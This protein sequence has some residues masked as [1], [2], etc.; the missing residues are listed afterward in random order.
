MT[1]AAAG[2]I[3]LAFALDAAAGEPPE[4]LHPVVHLGTAIDA[5]DR[6]WTRPVLVGGLVAFAVPLVS[7]GLAACVVAGA[8]TVGPLAESVVAGVLL[9]TTVSLRRLRTVAETVVAETSSNPDRA[10]DSVRALVGRDTDALDPAHLRSAAVESVAEN[11]ADGLT[12]PVLAFALG[13][14][15]SL[16]VAAGAA[17][18]VKAVD[19]LD[20]M[21]GYRE[22]PLGRASARL[23]DAA[24]W[25]PARV[26][27]VLLAVAAGRPTAVVAARRWAREPDSPNSGWPMATMAVVLDSGL[28]KPDAYRLG[29][30][31][32]LPDVTRARRGIRI[33]TVAG[34]LAGGTAGVIAWC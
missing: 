8:A 24:Q 28:R 26:A 30:S 13:S 2:A 19:T 1:V 12:G 5:L 18:W 17:T 9:F 31:R 25:L 6:D 32:P 22:Q 15:L 27:A 7:A 3:G 14:V 34:L 4:P 20:S 33:A 11:L 21:L 16:P 10:A 29:P 23:D